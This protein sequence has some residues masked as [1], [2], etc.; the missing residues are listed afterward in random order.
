[1][2]GLGRALVIG[3]LSAAFAGPAHAAIQVASDARSPTLRVDAQG[4]A[5][6]GWKAKDGTRHTLLIPPKGRVL[7]GGRLPGRDVSKT[8]AA[9]EI[10]YARVLR[11]TPDGAFWALQAWQV[12]RG[13]PTDLRFSRWRGEP[14]AVTAGATCCRYGGER[15]EGS[16]A[17]QGEPLFG[18]SP[19]TAGKQVRIFVYVDC[20]ACPGAAAGWKRIA[21]VATKPPGGSYSL[22]IGP[23]RLGARYRVTLARPNLGWTYAPD[24]VAVA[25]SA[26]SA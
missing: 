13:G 20:F 1:M 6:V 9:A 7:P 19:T 8:T 26:R 4:Y 16:A 25:E 18:S 3:L 10:P 12:V 11:Q 14:T 24:A 21:G 2:K 22:F 17:F 5:E 15:L 23:D